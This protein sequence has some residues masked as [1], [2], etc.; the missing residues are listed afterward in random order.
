MKELDANIQGKIMKYCAYQDRS[1]S[2]VIDKLYKLEVW[3]EEHDKY[4]NYLI[5]NLFLDEI[6]FTASFVRGKFR[7]KHWGKQKIK[8]HLKQKGIANSIIE[9]CINEE[10][11]QKEYYKIASELIDFKA[12]TLSETNPF[13]RKQKLANY[14]LQK[15]YES[16][17]IF[18]ILN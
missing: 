3:K 15:G 12:N 10:I 2:E 9:K 14:L 18:S 16:D 6:R 4:I 7:I 17:I 13:K 11:D 1:I 8:M 5:D